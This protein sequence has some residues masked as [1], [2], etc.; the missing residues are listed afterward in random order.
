M[1]NQYS[2]WKNVCG[3]KCAEGLFWCVLPTT[4]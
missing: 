1:D 3:P 2:E 4:F